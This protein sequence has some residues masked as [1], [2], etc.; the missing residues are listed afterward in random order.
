MS[1]ESKVIS[2]YNENCSGAMRALTDNSISIDDRFTA[3]AKIILAGAEVVNEAHY[4]MTSLQKEV[5]KLHLREQERFEK[6]VQKAIKKLETKELISEIAEKAFLVSWL[7]NKPLILFL[8]GIF[9]PS[10]AITVPADFLLAGSLVAAREKKTSLEGRI[11]IYQNYPRAL[12]DKKQY[13]I[14]VSEWEKIKE[15]IGSYRNTD[16]YENDWPS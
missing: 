15:K 13:E 7:V 8:G 5:V 16:F 11:W 1:I 2:K 3:V 4:K 9:P 14:G 12:H 10:L 6:K